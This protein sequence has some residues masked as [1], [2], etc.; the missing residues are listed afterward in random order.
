[1]Q[2]HFGGSYLPTVPHWGGQNNIHIP[3]IFL[4]NISQWL[5]QMKRYFYKRI[6]QIFFLAH[7]NSEQMRCSVLTYPKDLVSPQNCKEQRQL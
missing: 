6:L 5:L 1:M 3:T 2:K 4:I 7:R